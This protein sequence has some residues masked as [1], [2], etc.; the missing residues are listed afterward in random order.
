[1]V[2]PG[3]AVNCGEESRW[4]SSRSFTKFSGESFENCSRNTIQMSVRVLLAFSTHC[5]GEAFRT[6]RVRA[7]MTPCS[8]GS[9]AGNPGF[10]GQYVGRDFLDFIG[11]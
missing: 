4:H 1:M 9:T 2:K 6:K 8:A 5:S 11:V 7:P 3:S 10:F